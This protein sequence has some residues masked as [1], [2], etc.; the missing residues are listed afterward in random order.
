V[1]KLEL[2]F[3]DMLKKYDQE[4]KGPAKYSEFYKSAD[5]IFEQA[6]K[7]AK[8][9]INAAEEKGKLISFFQGT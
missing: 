2:S 1:E 8:L 3:Q 7:A 5:R 4:G 6:R 9:E